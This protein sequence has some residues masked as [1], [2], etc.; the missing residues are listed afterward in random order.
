ME[1]L[2]STRVTK[3]Y[4]VLQG[5]SAIAKSQRKN[6]VSCPW[7]PLVI[8]GKCGIVLLG[9][10][11]SEVQILSPRPNKL[12]QSLA[13]GEDFTITLGGSSCPGV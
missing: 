10:R 2:V 1:L 3:G 4:K 13:E 9:R 7:W 5:A 8:L 6:G 12:W 11:G